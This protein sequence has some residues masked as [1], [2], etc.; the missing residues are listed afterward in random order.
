MKG[1]AYV[2]QRGTQADRGNATKP[3]RHNLF[4]N[5]AM[6]LGETLI[7]TGVMAGQVPVVQS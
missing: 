3:L 2:D 1:G 6:H 5:S 7:D 4:H